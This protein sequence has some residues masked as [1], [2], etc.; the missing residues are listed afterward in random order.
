MDQEL[1]PDKNTKYLDLDMKFNLGTLAYEPSL[2]R[3]ISNQKLERKT[4]TASYLL[5]GILLLIL[6]FYFLTYY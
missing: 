5:I 1:I 2:P 4:K 6:I 3:K